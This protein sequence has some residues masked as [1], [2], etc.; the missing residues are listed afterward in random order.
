MGEGRRFI[1]IWFFIGVI[2]VAYGILILGTG[3]WELASPPARPVVMGYLHA[4]IW[5]GALILVL[6]IVYCVRFPPRRQ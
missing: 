6:G 3:L 1:P 2:L 5:W 4:G